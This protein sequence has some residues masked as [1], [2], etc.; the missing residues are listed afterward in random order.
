MNR[1]SVHIVAWN[2]MRYLPALFT[3]LAEQ[4]FQNFFVSVVDNASTD[5][6]LDW[7][8]SVYP[9]TA[10][11][12]NTRNLG[13]ARAHNQ[14]IALARARWAREPTNQNRGSLQERYVLVTNPDL[15]LASDFLE[16]LVRTADIHSEVGSF[17]GTLLKIFADHAGDDMSS[18]RRTTYID[19]TGLKI[20]RSRR[21]V[22]RGA[23]K[24]NRGQYAAGPVFG[25]SG[26]LALY[27]MNALEDVKFDNEYFDEDFFA[28]KEDV[29][30]A[31]R[32]Q[33]RGWDA[34][35]EPRA[36]AYHYRAAAGTERRTPWA[37]LTERRKKSAFVNGLSTR[38]HLL[39]LW[40]NDDR[41][42]RLLHLPWILMYECCRFILI[43]LTEPGTFKAYG[44]AFRFLP[45]MLRKR[46]FS[47]SIR[48]RTPR[49]MRRWFRPRAATAPKRLAPPA[50][51]TG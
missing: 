10:T 49:D 13:F 1:V 51:Q 38:N 32:L 45:R 2:S 31:W 18:P 6:A 39:L 16:Q 44:A 26:A 43:L 15:I 28:Y 25:I 50:R 14:M 33:L 41:T 46:A 36:V 22:E 29:D 7:L 23:G 48:K 3:S 24:E 27:R 21:V 35:Y 40:K 20:L 37:A 4:T 42:N 5:G 19:S 17:G 34:W 12:R 9:Q 47:F 30:L 11:L 8:R